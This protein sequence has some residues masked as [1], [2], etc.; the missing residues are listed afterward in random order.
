MLFSSRG[1]NNSQ[2]MG[3]PCAI[4]PVVVTD[5][6]VNWNWENFIYP[7]LEELHTILYGIQSVGTT[8]EDPEL[9]IINA[10]DYNLWQ[11]DGPDMSTKGYYNESQFFCTPENSKSKGGLGQWLW[12]EHS[13][14]YLDGAIKKGTIPANRLHP[15]RNNFTPIVGEVIEEEETEDKIGET[16]AE[17]K[18]PFTHRNDV[19]GLWLVGNNRNVFDYMPEANLTVDIWKIEAV[20]SQAYNIGPADD[21]GA[22]N[23]VAEDPLLVERI[24][25]LWIRFW[26]GESRLPTLDDVDKLTKEMFDPGGQYWPDGIPPYGNLPADYNPKWIKGFAVWNKKYIRESSRRIISTDLNWDAAGRDR[27]IKYFKKTY[28]SGSGSDYT[29]YGKDKGLTYRTDIISA[30]EYKSGV[31]SMPGNGNR[32]LMYYWSDWWDDMFNPTEEEEKRKTDN[33]LDQFGAPY[34][35]YNVWSSTFVLFGG[36]QGTPTSHPTFKASKEEAI[37][38]GRIKRSPEGDTSF[39][40]RWGDHD[41]V[42]SGPPLTAD[43]STHFKF[44]APSR[45]YSAQEFAINPPVSGYPAD[46]YLNDS[47]FLR[48]TPDRIFAH[49]KYEVKPE[50]FL[51]YHLKETAKPY[52]F[53][54]LMRARE[55]YMARSNSTWRYGR[56][57]DDVI[58]ENVWVGGWD[59]TIIDNWD[60]KAWAF[61]FESMNTIES[62]RYIRR[63]YDYDYGTYDYSRE[64]EYRNTNQ[65]NTWDIYSPNDRYTM[66]DSEIVINGKTFYKTF[67]RMKNLDSTTEELQA[68]S[69]TIINAGIENIFDPTWVPPEVN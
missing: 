69:I 67:Y 22:P 63:W 25:D 19:L 41:N 42:Q 36:S 37:Y 32:S 33:L 30:D 9:K 35:V 23:F 38:F 56:Y 68:P 49:Y 21:K 40:E 66:Q 60:S 64:W 65:K 5:N 28:V 13:G 12:D 24:K 10:G 26:K 8:F 18:Q 59:Q 43:T 61:Q 58:E 45:A 62:E 1:S 48:T 55:S 31:N 11:K 57:W 7:T 54:S 3:F 34:Q 51:G 53:I 20:T 17:F 39:T 27:Y 6:P 46:Y 47:V 50:N 16:L 29:M 2:G 14:S 4:E 15:F 52:N 44:Y